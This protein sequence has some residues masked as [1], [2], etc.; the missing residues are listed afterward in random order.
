MIATDVR[1]AVYNK[2]KSRA[3]STI[4]STQG[5]PDLRSNIS[6]VFGSKFL[7]SVEELEVDLDAPPVDVDG[8]DAGAG[9]QEENLD[10]FGK[11]KGKGK[12][13]G[14][15]GADGD[16][17]DDADEDGKHAMAVGFVSKA[18]TCTSAGRR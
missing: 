4:L 5:S 12:G 6:N 2:P 13:K 3:R 17:A 7:A 8:D 10:P 14:G 15:G 9:K 16:D 11:G 18:G 1:M